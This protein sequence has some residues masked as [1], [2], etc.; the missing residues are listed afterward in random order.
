MP[1]FLNKFDDLALRRY[2]SM[3][4]ENKMSELNYLIS[5]NIDS[6]YESKSEENDDNDIIGIMPVT[7]QE[8][9]DIMQLLMND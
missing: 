8:F 9:D 5:Q 6:F 2:I 3:T 4:E 7:N 1:R